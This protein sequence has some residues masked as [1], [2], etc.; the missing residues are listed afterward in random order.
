M[1]VSICIITYNQDKYIAKAIESALMQK[2]DFTYEIIISDD[3][4]TDDT[5]KIIAGY[6][7]KYPG[8]IKAFYAE[9]NLGMLR[10]W[11]KA[12][13]H[14]K[15]RYIALLEGDDFWTD[16]LKLIKQ[17]QLLEQSPD[18]SISFTNARILYEPGPQGFPDYVTLTKEFY[19]TSDLLEYNF[20]PTCS[21]LMR[22]NISETFFPEAYFKSPF[23]DWIIHVLNSNFGKIHFINEFSCTYLVHNKGV[24]GGIKKE[25]Q[26]LNKLTALAC[27]DEIINEDDLKKVILK[28]RKKILHEL[29]HYYREQGNVYNRLKFRIKLILA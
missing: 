12:L 1:D 24:W 27:I 26:L 2:F 22:N 8:V 5:Q 4:S 29:Y 13:S 21:V 19:S 28:S 15:G 17:Y 11:V 18:V 16:P 10:N 14:C 6:A 9:N 7:K 23:A 25:R 20:I 3:C